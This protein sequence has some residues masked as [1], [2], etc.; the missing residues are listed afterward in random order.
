[1]VRLSGFEPLA[2]QIRPWPGRRQFLQHPHVHNLLFLFKITAI[3]HR[4]RVITQK[5]LRQVS[6]LITI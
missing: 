2:Q 5:I 3:S 6:Q 4:N 1:L